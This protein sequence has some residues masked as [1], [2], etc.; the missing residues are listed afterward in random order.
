M[1]LLRDASTIARARRLRRVQ[2]DNLIFA[3]TYNLAAV[4]LCLAGL[5]NPIVAA[6]LMPVSSV[7]VVALT[8][9]RLG[10]RGAPWMS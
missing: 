1:Q 8:T 7:T 9:S 3:A 6:V 4:G 10:R 2:R 5:V